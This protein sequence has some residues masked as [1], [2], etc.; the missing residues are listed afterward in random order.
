MEP[1]DKGS[2]TEK[3]KETYKSSPEAKPKSEKRH[4][5]LAK[6]PSHEWLKEK[7]DWAEDHDASLA[8]TCSNNK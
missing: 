1:N 5:S 3:M 6:I 4:A 2:E 8:F 7:V